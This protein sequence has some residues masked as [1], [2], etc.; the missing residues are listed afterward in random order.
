MRSWDTDH[1]KAKLLA[2]KRDAIL[3]AARRRFLASGYEGA[4]MEAIAADA[5]VS[6]MTL[7]R[8]AKRKDELFEAVISIACDPDEH[9][10]ADAMAS[11]PLRS[12]LVA[13]AQ[14]FQRK[15][16]DTDMIA[17]LRAVISEQ[18]RFPDLAA[19]AYRAAIGHLE[20]FVAARLAAAE[21]GR[22]LDDETRHRLATKFADDLFGV[23]MFRALLGLG[24]TGEDER[25]GRVNRAVEG[26]MSALGQPAVA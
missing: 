13:T 20:D 7:Y 24:G 3:A 19:T 14:E 9:G 22:G 12:V 23:D 2:R 11:M 18:G 16:L 10:G 15:V 25:A 8:H 1:P 5:G 4:S 26:V 17:L 21:E 6:I